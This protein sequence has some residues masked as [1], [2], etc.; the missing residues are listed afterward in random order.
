MGAGTLGN[1]PIS[2]LNGVKDIKGKVNAT[3]GNSHNVWWCSGER[4][5]EGK[6]VIYTSNIEIIVSVHVV[7]NIKYD[8]NLFA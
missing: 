7:R 6:G 1:F 8:T 2:N 5:E 3:E 4:R